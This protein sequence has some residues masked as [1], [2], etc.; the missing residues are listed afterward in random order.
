MADLEFVKQSEI[1]LSA[2][3]AITKAALN[4][5]NVKYA[6]DLK[7]EGFTFLAISP[8]YVATSDGCK[9]FQVIVLSLILII[10]QF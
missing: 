10:L 2:P 4:M 3:Y 5:V 6:V 7:E 1:G 9:L 8:G